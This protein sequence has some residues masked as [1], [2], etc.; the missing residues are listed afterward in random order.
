MTTASTDAATASTDGRAAAG[1]GVDG[2]VAAAAAAT[3]ASVACRCRK[4]S[5]YGNLLSLLSGWSPAL[6]TSRCA[7][8]RSALRCPPLPMAASAGS[9]TL[10]SAASSHVCSFLVMTSSRGRSLSSMM[11]RRRR[12]SSGE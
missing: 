2:S 9:G 1:G 7:L 12:S 10:R 8:S 4:F 11:A 3:R 5:S 6:A